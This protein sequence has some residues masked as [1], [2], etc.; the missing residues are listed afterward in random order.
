MNRIAF[1]LAAIL[2][3]ITGIN[4]T[5]QNTSDLQAMIDR[6]D[7][8]QNNGQFQEA[9]SLFEQARQQCETSPGHYTPEMRYIMGSLAVCATQISDFPT[10]VN[11]LIET[12]N[13]AQKIG[14]GEDLSEFHA[15]FYIAHYLTFR[16]ATANELAKAETYLARAKNSKELN[17]EPSNIII[18][19]CLERYIQSVKA[20]QSQSE[21]SLNT[22]LQNFKF[23]SDNN[24]YSI[25][26]QNYHDDCAVML[27]HTMLNRGMNDECIEHVNTAIRQIP[28]ITE[29]VFGLELLCDKT[30]ALANKGKADECIELGKSIL[31]KYP[32]EQFPFELRFQIIYNLALS[33]NYLEKYAEALDILDLVY[34]NQNYNHLIEL[35]K[36]ILDSAK[37]KSL[38]GLK[39]YDK[40]EAILKR[41]LSHNPEGDIAL[42]A[43][44]LMASISAQRQN[45]QELGYVDDFMKAANEMNYNNPNEGLTYYDLALTYANNYQYNKALEALDTAI[46]YF[47]QKSDK[48]SQLNCFQAKLKK[49]SIYA[50]I[51]YISS[52]I[53][54]LGNQI[55]STDFIN[56]IADKF[57]AKDYETVAYCLEMLMEA[58]HHLFDVMLTSIEMAEH[59]GSATPEQITAIREQINQMIN[60]ALTNLNPLDLNTEVLSWLKENDPDRLGFLHQY[61]ALFYRELEDCKGGI[62]YLDKALADFDR[63]NPMYEILLDLKEMLHLQNGNI[64]D[65][66]NFIKQRYSWEKNYLTKLVNTYTRDQRK[67]MWAERSGNLSTYIAMTQKAD[68]PWLNG[69]AYDASILSKGLLLLADNHFE[70]RCQRSSNPAVGQLYKQW[71]SFGEEESTEAAKTE[72]EL[73]R[74]LADEPDMANKIFNCS[75]QDV[76]NSLGKNEFAVEFAAYYN[77]GLH[78]Y[79][80]LV[81]GKGFEAPRLLRLCD[82]KALQRFSDESNTGY[83]DLSA[84]I[85]KKLAAI[86]P[87]KAKV[88][89]APVGHLHA[90]PLENLPDFEA[91]DRLISD[92]WQLR[93]VS[94]TREV[95][96]RR[97][98]KTKKDVEIFGGMEYSFNPE[99]IMADYLALAPTYRT[100]DIATDDLR[101]GTS[102][103]E[104]LPGSKREIAEIAR[105]VREGGHKA[106]EYAGRKPTEAKFKSEAGTKGDILH[107]STHGFYFKPESAEGGGFE[108]LQQNASDNMERALY[109]SGL[110]MAGVNET[111]SQNI[112]IEKCEDGILT[113]KE[114]SMMDLSD[115]GTV[116]LSAC[117]TGVGHI[118]G[119]GVFGLQRGFKMAGAQTIMM[120]LWKVDDNA[121]EA[122][123]TNFYKNWFAGHDRSTALAMAQNTIRTT[124]GW[125]SPRYWAGF[126]L[127]DDLN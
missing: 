34:G 62:A 32:E 106:H 16:D 123:M 98:T 125:E 120:S 46:R 69:I 116:V 39:E 122:L 99:E 26:G 63:Q 20:Y 37:A 4:I 95:A 68:L 111:L 124:P 41:I 83:S 75:W 9:I 22:Q 33:Y 76:A 94:S 10:I 21:Q 66:E 19:E 118:F 59:D 78:H 61:T 115:V 29:Y 17:L 49:V 13:I 24:N 77:K 57:K 28:D 80:A 47:S 6:A 52:E 90:L 86:L 1:L 14:Y 91:S 50:K 104:D 97:Q 84:T 103:V 109:G 112:D 64:A 3:S 72:R 7:A 127:L 48:D 65:S 100:R 12:D 114:I 31:E 82:S 81:T 113:A 119:D 35:D 54:D 15:C 58:Q 101:K 11:A 126:I 45:H 38:W 74:L 36:D 55:Q 89:F 56:L 117:E 107:I 88:Y 93:R 85:W 105:I 25:W 53:L 108:W 8:L 70:R 96:A 121:T 73:I 43:N 67:L 23:L 18:S 2:L 30:L 60:Q 51:D 79:I 71:K 42:T 5:A 87:D 102:F 44:Y 110:M 92:R 27:T 40:A